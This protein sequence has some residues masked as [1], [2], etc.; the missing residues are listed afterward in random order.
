[1]PGRPVLVIDDDEDV[2]ITVAEV[3]RDEGYAVLGAAS[4]REAL[5]LLHAAAVAPALILLDLMMPGMDGW[6]FRR[7]QQEVPT[8]ALVPTF[9]FSA[10]DPLPTRTD[11]LAATGWLRKPLSLEDLLALVARFA[12]PISRA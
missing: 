3:L 4:G 2:R 8:L 6:A 9:I 12:A 5:A 1:V 11:E 7:A 10:Y